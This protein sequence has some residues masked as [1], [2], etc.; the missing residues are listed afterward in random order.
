M[1]EFDEEYWEEQQTPEGAEI[2]VAKQAWNAG[3]ES[4]ARRL[5]TQTNV[6]P[7]EVNRIKNEIQE[8]WS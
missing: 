3:I 8:E 5:K 2:H 7:E 1:S 4:I 6:N